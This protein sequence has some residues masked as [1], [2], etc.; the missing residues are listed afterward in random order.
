MYSSGSR[1]A[2]MSNI[3]S[4][5]N[6][7]GVAVMNAGGVDDNLVELADSTIWGEVTEIPD[8]SDGSYCSDK[9]GLLISG[10]TV[11]AKDIHPTS[12]S[13]LPIYKIKSDAAWGGRQKIYNVD[14]YGWDSKDTACGGE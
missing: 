7:K 2:K 3:I 14:F 12:A 6:V 10:V 13:A 11:G 9:T 1:H 5:D 4:I 8:S